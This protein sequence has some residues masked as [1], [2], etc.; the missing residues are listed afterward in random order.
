MDLAGGGVVSWRL[1]DGGSIGP[2]VAAVH[3]EEG[4]MVQQMKRVRMSL[5]T[6]T[7]MGAVFLVGCDGGGISRS[8]VSEGKSQI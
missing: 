2:W 7:S 6:A 8:I 3:V 4:T 5:S 1:S